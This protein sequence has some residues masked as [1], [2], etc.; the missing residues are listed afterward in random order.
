M[1]LALGTYGLEIL[2]QSGKSVKTKSQK[3]LGTN[4]Y[5]CRSYRRKIARGVFLA[6]PSWIGLKAFFWLSTSVVFLSKMALTFT[7]LPK[8]SVI[9]RWN[10]LSFPKLQKFFPFH[11]PSKNFSNSGM[12]H[13]GFIFIYLFFWGKYL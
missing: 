7:H 6:S 5:V 11:L 1:G 13:S 2:H 3:I 10:F 9:L 4:S 8:L 12:K